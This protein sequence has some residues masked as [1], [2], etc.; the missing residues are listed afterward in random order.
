[1]NAAEWGN[2]QLWE[3]LL[4][5]PVQWENIQLLRVQ[6]LADLATAGLINLEQ[7]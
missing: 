3:L 7:E 1:M 6:L 2:I 4:A 5:Y